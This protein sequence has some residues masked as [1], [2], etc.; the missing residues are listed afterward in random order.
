MTALVDWLFAR[1]IPDWLFDLLLRA[2]GHLYGALYARYAG[3][4]LAG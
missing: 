2:G 4:G 3:D 1:L